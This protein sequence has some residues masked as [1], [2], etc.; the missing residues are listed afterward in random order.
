MPAKKI[1]LLAAVFALG[2][3][4]AGVLC[5][6]ALRPLPPAP[7]IPLPIPNGYDDFVRAGKL[8][9][10]AT[11]DYHSMSEAELRKFVSENS[12]ALKL[13][14]AGLAKECRVPIEFSTNYF[15]N[16]MPALASTRRL[17]FAMA[18]EGRLAELENRSGDAAQSYLE[19]IRF[20]SESVRGG[21]L[22][23]KLVGLAIEPIG[24]TPLEKLTTR[25]DANQCRK[26][27]ADLERLQPGQ[28]SLQE[29][30]ENEDALA[31]HAGFMQKIASML[32]Y[33][34]FS[35]GK[36]LQR[37]YVPKLNALERRRGLLMINLAGRAYELENGK[38]ASSLADLSPSYLKTIPQDPDT[39][40]NFVSLP[41][42]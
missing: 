24:L 29:V 33:K 21:F 40:T 25:L 16:H 22:I 30:L 34:S 15:E 4:L 19:T 26:A 39:G 32:A 41:R 31:R 27:L 38:P 20:S 36:V 37:T 28:E 12:E 5:F 6:L 11:S 1:N 9:S 18:A 35:P 23:D 2:I 10:E 42:Q 7:K 13:V 3:L 8:V 14:R 17:P